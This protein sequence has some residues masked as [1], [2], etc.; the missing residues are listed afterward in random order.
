MKIK[1]CERPTHDCSLSLLSALLFLLHCLSHTVVKSSWVWQLCTAA[2]PHTARQADCYR[3]EIPFSKERERE[4]EHSSDDFW[5]GWR[6]GPTSAVA[7]HSPWL[8]LP[9]HL[10]Q[11][12]PFSLCAVLLLNVSHTVNPPKAADP[13]TAAS[14]QLEEEPAMACEQ[15]PGS[16]GMEISSCPFATEAI[17]T[18]S[19]ALR[20]VLPRLRPPVPRHILR[21]QP[22]HLV[23]CTGGYNSRQRDPQRLGFPQ[24]QAARSSC[25]CCLCRAAQDDLAATA[26]ALPAPSRAAAPGPHHASLLPQAHY[27]AT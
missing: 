21:C 15:L 22:Y 23:C 16:E 11:K 27:P 14:T 20:W 26:I 17:R 25:G 8:R 1:G 3:T 24:G 5:G 19:R 2:L 10:A 6:Y 18:H 9:H 4:R 7:H 13:Q 12:N